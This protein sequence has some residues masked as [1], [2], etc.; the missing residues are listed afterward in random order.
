[1]KIAMP[2]IPYRC[3][4]IVKSVCMV[5]AE[6]NSRGID[7]ILIVTDKAVHDLGLLDRLKR[8]LEANGVA[9]VIYDGTTANPTVTD[10]ESAR[11]MYLANRC[12]GVIGFG[13]GSAMDCAKAVGARIARPHKSIGRMRGILQVMRPLPFLAAVPTTAGTGSETTVT[14]VITDESTGHKFPISD[15]ALIPHMAI[16]DP[17]V[18]KSLPMAVTATTG[19]DTLTHAIEAYIGRSTLKQTRQDSLKAAR[20]VAE[21]LE[22]A[23]RDGSDMEARA[24]MLKAAYHGGRAFSKAYMGYCHAVAHSLGGKYHIPHGLANAVILPHVLEA[25]GHTIDKQAKE[26]CIA[27]HIADE[28]TP[29]RGCYRVLTEYVRDMN[30][31][32]GIPER[33]QGI[34]V[35]D[36]PELARYAD[37]EAN[38]LYPVP[39]LMDA[40]ELERFYRVIM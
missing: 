37:K 32:L 26:L 25:F 36:I 8:V 1:M 14:T 2:L 12:R 29:E 40:K 27:M 18:T 38:P 19:M 28:H 30:K 13:G 22:K 3:P 35:E 33:L 9:Y 16:H 10:V 7:S 21:N 23:C 39:V 31:K 4:K 6:L 20:L 15:P 5:P 24:N 11:K 34:R 17:M